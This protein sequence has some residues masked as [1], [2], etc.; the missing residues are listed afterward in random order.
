MP[1]KAKPSDERLDETTF[2]K[3]KRYLKR[4]D[5][6]L[7]AWIDRVG[8]IDLRQE[9]HAFRTLCRSILAQQLATA[10]ARTIHARFA[11]LF[12]RKTPTASRLAEMDPETLRPC[13]ISA[14][15]AEYMITLAK[16]FH[17]GSLKGVRFAKLDNE[18]IIEKLSALP[19]IGRWTAEMFLIFSLGR[20]DVFSRGDLALRNGMQRVLGESESIPPKKS[21]EIAERW[22]PYRSIASLYL[23]KIS[24]WSD[25]KN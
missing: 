18:S 19:G 21:I 22:A 11:D 8:N 9:P 5:P 24:H 15:K 25:D 12:P 3:G 7:K 13:G 16:E 20:L 14:R 6:E 2:A 23:W 17:S 1:S 10:A 4:K